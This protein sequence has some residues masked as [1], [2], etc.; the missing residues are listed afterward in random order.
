MCT[1]VWKE[2]ENRTGFS[3]AA[4]QETKQEIRQKILRG[5]FRVTNFMRVKIDGIG[6]EKTLIQ[7]VLKL[8]GEFLSLYVC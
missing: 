4:S 1:E 7:A 3:K 6:S 5:V 8:Q 2:K